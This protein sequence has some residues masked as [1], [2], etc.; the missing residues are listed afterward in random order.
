MIEVSCTFAFKGFHGIP[1]DCQLDIYHVKDTYVVLLTD[2]NHGTSVTNACEMIATKVLSTYQHLTPKNTV[3]VEH[4]DRMDGET[5]DIITFAW[6]DNR[7]ASSPN[8][9]R[10]TTKQWED[11]IH[12][13]KS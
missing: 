3:W 2:Q 9:Q 6:E 10:I 7:V 12:V 5:F 11:M 1:S 13:R 8:W 4:Y